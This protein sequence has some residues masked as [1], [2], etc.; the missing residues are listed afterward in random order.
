M[1]G[2]SGWNRR[3]E[4]SCNCVLRAY[5]IHICQTNLVEIKNSSGAPVVVMIFIEKEIKKI[6]M[7]EVGKTMYFDSLPLGEYE[8]RVYY[9]FDGDVFKTKVKRTL[10]TRDEGT[11]RLYIYDQAL[12][13]R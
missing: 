5:P 4:I 1:A 13:F 2:L 6:R 11:Y 10:R 8:F 7:I 9:G 3:D 12:H